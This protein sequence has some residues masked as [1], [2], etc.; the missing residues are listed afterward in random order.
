LVDPLCNF[1]SRSN[2][3]G[4]LGKR[5]KRGLIGRDRTLRN[6]GRRRKVC[7]RFAGRI[8]CCDNIAGRGRNAIRACCVGRSD[9][10][11]KSF[12]ELVNAIRTFV[13]QERARDAHRHREHRDEREQG[14]IGQRRR[15]DGTTI[16]HEAF[17]NQ[18]PEVQKSL[19][20]RKLGKRLRLDLPKSEKRPF[21]HDDVKTLTEQK[22]KSIAARTSSHI[23]TRLQ[24]GESRIGKIKTVLTVFHISGANR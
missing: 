3:F 18:N 19:E 14:G 13:F 12:D 7:N 6:S 17:P 22:A 15:P 20:A 16:S 21:N 2:G 9:A 8:F 24:P 1:F 5:G 4:V 23:N 10:G 11:Y